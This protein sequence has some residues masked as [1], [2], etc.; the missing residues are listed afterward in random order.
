MKMLLAAVIHLL[1]FA[2]AVPAQSPVS[3]NRD[4]A[5]VKFVTSDID[6]FWRAFDMAAKESDKAKKA[7]IYQSEYLDKGSDGLK[8]FIRLRI[9]TAESLADIIE[10][11]LKF[12]ASARPSTLQ[13]TNMQKRMRKSFR[14]FKKTYPDAVFPNVYFMIGNTS[15]GGTTGPSGLLIGTELYSKTA[16]TPTEELPV[17]LKV[18]LSPVDVLPAIVAHESCHH[19]QSLPRPVTV[20][21]KSIQE[22]SCDLISEIISG[23]NINSAQKIYGDAREAELWKEFAADMSTTNIRNWMYNGVTAKDKPGDLGYYIGYKISQAYYRKASDKKQAIRDIL[24][25]KDFQRFYEASGY[26]GVSE[27]DKLP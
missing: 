4:A 2:I 5:A 9:K 7:A 13:V 15:T 10:K 19:N 6:N 27:N 1:F 17:W 22:G 12:Y 23:G 24:N 3:V 18:V 8:D 11:N 21:E 20:L 26:N 25:I 14:K 16:A